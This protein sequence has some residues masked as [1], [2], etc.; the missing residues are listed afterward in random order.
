MNQYERQVHQPAFEIVRKLAQTLRKPA[1]YFYATDDHLAELIALY[2]T[3]PSGKRRQLLAAA[4]S[5][6]SG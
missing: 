1:P 3:L 2:G 6:H 4:R 5:L